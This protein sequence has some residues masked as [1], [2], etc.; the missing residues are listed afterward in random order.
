MLVCKS[1]YFI[2][3]QPVWSNYKILT[4][5]QDYATINIKQKLQTTQYDKTKI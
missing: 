2:L 5:A 3:K 4:K 1:P